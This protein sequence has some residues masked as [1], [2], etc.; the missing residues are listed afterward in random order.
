[1]TRHFNRGGVPLVVYVKKAQVTVDTWGDWVTCKENIYSFSETNTGHFTAVFTRSL[2]DYIVQITA[3]DEAVS[4]VSNKN[5]HSVSFVC[6]DVN[7][8]TPRT[9]E[10]LNVQ[11]L[12]EEKED[13]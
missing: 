13:E 10:T 1:M 5:R 11:I 2:S 4:L 8:G 7:N 12:V 9:P 6:L 3:S